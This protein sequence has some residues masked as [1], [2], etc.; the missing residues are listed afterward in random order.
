MF[1]YKEEN[2]YEI[3]TV[4]PH[5]PIISHNPENPEILK[6][7]IQTAFPAH[8]PHPPQFQV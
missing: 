4:H 8:S 7:L 3:Y 5:Q 6:I 2:L 1:K